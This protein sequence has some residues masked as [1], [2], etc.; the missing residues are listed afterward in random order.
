MQIKAYRA[1]TT[2]KH[3]GKV[4][5]AG[6]T[7]PAEY[8]PPFSAQRL[9]SIGIITETVI[10]TNDNGSSEVAFPL[11]TEDGIVTETVLAENL[12]DALL[13]LQKNVDDAVEGINE[14]DNEAVLLMVNALDSRKTVLSAIG[15]RIAVL[16][17]QE[18][19]ENPEGET[20][21]GDAPENPEGETPEEDD[22]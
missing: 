13:L 20:P 5:L 18:A 19:G 9:L 11:L 6:A 8:I 15:K 21:E 10:D 2:Q 1:S 4:F 12:F 14:C 22:E 3:G 16:K 7:I 17:E